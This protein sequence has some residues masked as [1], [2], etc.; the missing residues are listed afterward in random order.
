MYDIYDIYYQLLDMPLEGQ[1]SKAHKLI[2]E[3]EIYHS[4]IY[5][6][7]RFISTALLL[8]IDVICVKYLQ[9]LWFCLHSTIFQFGWF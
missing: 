6:Y 9:I 5:I 4:V 7:M 1:Y 8:I 2:H 3:N